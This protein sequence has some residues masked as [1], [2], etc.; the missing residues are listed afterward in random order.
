[1][2]SQCLVILIGLALHFGWCTKALE[3]HKGAS[4]TLA[5]AEQHYVRLTKVE[6]SMDFHE[7]WGCHPRESI[8]AAASL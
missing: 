1:M 4:V 3:S 5:A 8:N 6:E 2:N 7:G